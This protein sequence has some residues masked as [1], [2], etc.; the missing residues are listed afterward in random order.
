VD[1]NAS[2]HNTSVFRVEIRVLRRGCFVGLG[3]GR[4]RGTGQTHS[5]D[6][7]EI[8]R[9]CGAI[10]RNRNREPERKVG[11]KEER[12]TYDHLMGQKG[13]MKVK[14]NSRIR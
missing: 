10:G 2:E 14:E 12:G 1:T 9:W 11:Q 5:R 6:A 8:W 7:I 4:G 13:E 3:Q